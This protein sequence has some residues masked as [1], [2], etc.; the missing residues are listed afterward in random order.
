MVTAPASSDNPAMLRVTVLP[1]AATA[2]PGVLYCW[3][4]AT[5]YNT[6]PL[7]G[8]G[9]SG[10]TETAICVTYDGATWNAVQMDE[11]GS[12]AAALALKAPLAS[13][14]LTGDPTITNP[15][16]G[17]NTDILTLAIGSY[18]ATSV[19]QRIKFIGGTGPVYNLGYMGVGF[20]PATG[21]D[22]YIAFGTGDTGAAVERMRITKN[23]VSI[24]ALI[25]PLSGMTGTL[26]ESQVSGL[27]ADLAAKAPSMT[28]AFDGRSSFNAASEKL[29]IALR[30]HAGDLPV[31]LGADHTTG[32]FIISSASGVELFRVDQ[33]GQVTLTGNLSGTSV[34][35]TSLYAPIASL[36]GTLPTSAEPAHTG[37]VTNAAGS[38]AMTVVAVGGSSAS[39]VHNA[40]ALVHAATD[41]PTA[42]TIVKRDS[43]GSASF[44]KITATKVSTPSLPAYLTNAL[45]IAGGLSAGDEYRTGGDPDIKCVVH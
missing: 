9:G 13:P 35:A 45:A 36:T 12:I 34:S 16:L 26:P 11:Y 30:Y 41:A 28:P 7:L 37:D 38:L 27:V 3:T 15:T 2:L 33:V 4:Q 24:P 25:A 32:D 5:D 21:A 22:G 40:E 10:G 20:D 14:G 42:A 8:A 19:E 23:G 39:D 29:A 43:F 18:T 44:Y 17:V 31:W 1:T 6:A